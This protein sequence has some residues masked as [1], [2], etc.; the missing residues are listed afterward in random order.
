MFRRLLDAILR[1]TPSSDAAPSPSVDHAGNRETTRV[2]RLSTEERDWEAASQQR[3]R[4]R[5][6]ASS[7]QAAKQQ[8]HDLFTGEEN[9]G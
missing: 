2:G 7:E 1:R 9:A 5:Q 4:D 3:S 8:A 6:A